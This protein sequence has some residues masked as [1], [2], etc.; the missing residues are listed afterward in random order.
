MWLNVF[1]KLGI[2]HLRNHKMLISTSYFLPLMLYLN[3]WL[4][5][6]VLSKQ[7]ALTC[8]AW[9]QVELFFPPRARARGAFEKLSHRHFSLVIAQGAHS[10][11]K[12]CSCPKE[13][14]PKLS[15]ASG[16]WL[17]IWGIMPHN[18]CPT[19]NLTWLTKHTLSTTRIIGSG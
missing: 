2:W 14:I 15:L 13:W 8:R 18:S 9:Y 11:T 16:G 17:L 3:P 12:L 1:V 19:P 4:G 5:L 10:R 7:T 6:C